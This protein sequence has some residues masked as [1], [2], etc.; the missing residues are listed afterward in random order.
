MMEYVCGCTGTKF[1]TI[2]TCFINL[3]TRLL[4]ISA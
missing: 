4:L 1:C 3:C 2:L